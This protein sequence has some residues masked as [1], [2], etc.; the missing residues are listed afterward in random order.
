MNSMNSMNISAV[1]Y[2]YYAF[3]PSLS[4]SKH[5]FFRLGLYWSNNVYIHALAEKSMK[6]Y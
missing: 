1:H 6:C 2:Q 3:S 5:Y 4:S